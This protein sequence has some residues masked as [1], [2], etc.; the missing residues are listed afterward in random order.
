ME[1]AVDR[2]GR[3]LG[4]RGSL[5]HEAGAYMPWGVV[6]P[7]IAATSVPGPYVIPNFQLDVSV[8]FTNKVPTSPVRGAGRPEAAVV[9]E[10]LM[11]RLARELK[12]DRAEV[13]RRNFIR[14]AQMPYRVGIISRDG[15]PV[16]YDSGDYPTCQQKALAA[17]DY[18]G[19]AKR[20]AEARAHGRYIGLG[21]GNAVESTGLGPYESAIIRVSTSGKVTV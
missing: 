4:L 18:Q 21:I 6:L 17:A 12:L 8:A 3:I 11:D 2:E 19:F 1:I 5:I 13:R 15:R 7:W 14:P 9:M 20:Q 16:T 10:R